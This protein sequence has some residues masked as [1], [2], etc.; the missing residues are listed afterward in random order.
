MRYSAI[1]AL[2]AAM[3][4]PVLA[5]PMPP[6]DQPPHPFGPAITVQGT[7]EVRS[8]PEVAI[9]RLGV[10]AQAPT[11]QAAQ[12]RASGVAS[13]ILAAVRELG[14]SEAQVQTS[15]LS[16]SP[17]YA[18]NPSPEAGNEPRITGY[19]ATNTV[20]VRLEVM[21]QVG[22][23]IDAGLKAG[24]NRV[25]GVDFGLKDE[26]P[27]RARALQQAVLQA[28]RKAEAIAGSL[29]VHLGEVLGAEEG[30]GETVTPRFAPRGVVA[31]SAPA[32]TPVSA[33]QITT[34]ATVT[35]RYRISP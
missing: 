34:S 12:Q 10:V 30:G 3:T 26:G 25:D 18:N 20:S 27:A 29:N 5:Q 16:L 17:L 1:P 4:L 2:L 15:D 6:A 19:Q 11:A 33:G 21:D 31:M 28:R 8:D 24:A 9:V 32:S 23:M 13:A 14:V 7:A 35:V 22:Q